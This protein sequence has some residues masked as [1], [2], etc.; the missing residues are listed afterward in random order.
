MAQT[1][2]ATIDFG[3]SPGSQGSS[4][5]ITGQAA[6]ASGS[7]CEAWLMYST[8]ANHNEVEHLIVPMNLRCGS[9]VA[10]TGFTIY[11]ASSWVL[12]GAW[13]VQWVWN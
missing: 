13:T 2:T 12:T 6:I 5:V 7:L 9:I 8:S 11:A 4:V 1:G 3:S 10:G